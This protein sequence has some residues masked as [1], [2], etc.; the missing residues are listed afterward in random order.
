MA[1]DASAVGIGWLCVS[2]RAASVPNILTN[3]RTSNSAVL[4]A[5]DGDRN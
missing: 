4:L 2:R 3:I 5:S 1:D